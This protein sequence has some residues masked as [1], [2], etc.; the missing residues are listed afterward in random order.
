V[1]GGEATFEA[2]WDH[3][4]ALRNP[5]PLADLDVIFFDPVDTSEEHEREVER[6]LN[7]ALPGAPWEARNQ[8]AV[9]LWFPEKFGYEVE[10]FA[11]TADAVASWPETSTAVGVCLDASDQMTIVAPFGVDEKIAERWPRVTILPAV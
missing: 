11:P 6:A 2:I 8:A 5:T 3:L 7:T 10:P 1:T 9:H 4:H